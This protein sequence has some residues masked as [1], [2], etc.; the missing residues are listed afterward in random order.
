MANTYVSKINGHLVKDTE[1]REQ[2]A[3]KAA[4]SHTHTIANVDGL[5]SALNGKADQADY[6]QLYDIVGDNLDTAKKYTDEKVASI[7]G[8]APETLDTLQ[9]LAKALD[10]NEN[11]A[12][13]VATE[14]G[15]KANDA[16]LK[17]VAKS[18]SYN[19]LTDKP[20]LANE[21]TAGLMSAEDKLILDGL[22]SQMDQVAEDFG[23][24]FDR[25]AVLEGTADS[26][27]AVATSG[28]YND[29][30]DKPTIPAA[31]TV[32][33][34][35]SSTSANPVQNKVI[36]SALDSKVTL[37]TAQEITGKKTLTNNFLVKVSTNDVLAPSG[38]WGW[39]SPISKYL[40]HDLLAFRDAKAEYSTDGVTWIEDTSDSYRRN[41]TNQKE[42]Q[43]ITVISD[44]RTHSRFTWDAGSAIWHAC[45]AAWL[46]IGFT[47]VNPAATCTIKFQSS[48]DGST[49]TDVF[50][51]SMSGN[52]AP[53]WLKLNES[54]WTQCRAVRLAMS[55]TSTSGSIALSSVRWLTKRW[56]NQG[57][58][59]ELETPFDWNNDASII[60]RK[61][62]STL[63]TSSIPWAAV[64]GNTLYENGVALSSKYATITQL[65]NKADQTDVDQLYETIN[66]LHAVATSG[67]YND[68]TDKPTIPSISGLATTS[69][70]D[71]K[72]ASKANQTDV[73]A[74]NQDMDLV[75]QNFVDAF[76]RIADLEGTAD[77]LHKVATS[78]SYSDLTNKPT[79]PTVNNGTLTIQKNGTNVA[80]FSANQSGNATANITVPTSVND[81]SSGYLNTHPE[82]SS[83]IIPFIHNDLAFL[84]Y[85]GGSYS[86]YSTTSTD[87]TVADL[88]KNSVTTS[89][90]DN[91]FDGS[92][93]Y[94]YIQTKVETL[95]VIDMSLHKDFTYSNQFYIDFGSV[96]WRAK[97]IAVYAM[98]SK[99]ETKYTL[100]N[101]TTSN[102]KGN[103]YCSVAH[104]SK[105]SAGTTEQGF[106]KLRVV[107]SGWN[108]PN[109]SS[110][111][112]IAQIGLINFSSNG[113]KETYV[114]RGGSTMYGDLNTKN[115][116]PTA[117]NASDLGSSGKQYKAI[118]GQTLYENGTALSSKYAKD[119]DLKAVAKTGS[120][121][122]L[123]D[124]PTIPAAVTVDSTLSSTSTNPVQ[125][126]VINSALVGKTSASVLPNNSGEIKTKYRVAQKGDAGRT[127]GTYRYYK[128]CDLPANDAS[129]YASAI[130]SGRIGGWT[131]GD[132]SYINALVWNRGTPGIAL[133]DIAGAATAMST[134]WNTCELVLY[135]NDSNTASLFAKCYSWFT[136]DLDIELFQSTA[137][138]TY[139]GTY[140]TL[141]PAG[142]LVARSSTS[143]KRLEL[144][145][146]KL[147][148]D[149]TE[150]PTVTTLNNYVTE[151]R[152]QEV[153]G[154]YVNDIDAL[155]GG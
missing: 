86:L 67:S 62:N 108:S 129:N 132:M 20:T 130:I 87:F 91:M 27:H 106:N 65:G 54:L 93:S 39:A 4:L 84:S 155:L 15:K 92:P 131:S 94:G 19:D 17:A 36:N 31:V 107:L 138:I 115:L 18:G 126:K 116:Y 40:W 68:L 89:N 77:S 70:V 10:E 96:S 12:T 85:K 6:D 7:V 5:Q 82:N 48:T 59:S 52:Q 144:I 128:I 49:F 42:N 120:Y 113:V 34:A 56:G 38:D 1:A 63:G 11:F 90:L 97:N 44:S 32:D 153:L 95:V 127:E 88:T 78:G 142:T 22:N 47:Y 141:T 53:Y 149:G 146:G 60:R 134:I 148:V 75:T 24:A 133:I 13:T 74:L 26:L 103:W 147:Y 80:T 109:D 45:Q 57:F 114:S 14:I 124:K 143:D 135:K 28:S 25:I 76:G 125:N 119:A 118:Y 140:A 102:S 99:N 79:I 33:S 29:L 64:Y 51:K 154:S 2:L 98:N 9:E 66:G 23:D 111:K 71:T 61:S 123:A 81:L 145:G 137:S 21:S 152:L 100:K 35:L 55:R 122:D 150:M 16:D 104:S 121:N 41:L 110:H 83:T 72:V 37:S 112:R 43:T 8:S 136:F 58:G 69:Y 46:I 117:T 73:D 151:T 105:N 50:T 30:K 3:G 101:S 139:D